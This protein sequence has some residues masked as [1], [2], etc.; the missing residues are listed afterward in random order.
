[1]NLPDYET[2]R[3]IW[4]VL[5]G[6][7]LIAF[8]VMDGFDLGSGMLLLFVARG[9]GQRRMVIN[10][11]GPVWEG[12]Q[13][14]LILGA[15]AIFAAWPL[16]YAT[17]FSGFYLAMILALAALIIRPVA[18]VY[19]SKMPGA[20]WRR[21]WDR[22]LFV[23]STI[24]P[25]VFG[26]ALG[27]T[28]EGAP[29]QLDQT[30]RLTYSGSLLDLF[31]PF[32]LLTGV[33]SLAMTAMHGAAYIAAKTEESVA[34]RA[35]I[36]GFA[37]ALILIVLF[38]AAGYWVATGLPGYR[39]TGVFAHDAASNPL[40]KTVVREAGAW[41]ANYRAMPWTMIAP[42]L[43]FAGAGLAALALALGHDRS[44]LTASGLGVFGVVATVG[45][46][47]FPFIL[48]S[49]LDPASSLTVWDASSSQSTLFT[50]LIAAAL[51]LPLILIYTAFIYRVLRGRV[52]ET[53]VEAD[54]ASY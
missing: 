15:G 5:L 8:A 4:W 38:A 21:N 29:F 53:D 7:L 16:V 11:I 20:L 51:F 9:D 43:G 3:V 13:V 54:H 46:S 33:V 26:I 31:N 10:A 40:A 17:A 6:V 30:M 37:A 44:A 22:L 18:I 36:A 48:P 35:R 32:A 39:I 2:L 34:F 49:S 45:V 14:W 12:N 24:P 1:M 52:S 28:L 19:R 47:M 23:A 50:M 41:I 25:L 27:N 42:G